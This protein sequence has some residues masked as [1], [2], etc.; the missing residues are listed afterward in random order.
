MASRGDVLSQVF[1]PFSNSPD[2]LLLKMISDGTT[3]AA[4]AS[5]DVDLGDDTVFD[6]A[7]QRGSSISLDPTAP[8]K[9]NLT[10]GL[11]QINF[12]AW[13]QTTSD[14]YGKSDTQI[15]V[16]TDPN[17]V[18]SDVLWN[19]N[20][21][22]FGNGTSTNVTLVSDESHSIIFNASSNITLYFRVYNQNDASKTFFVRSIAPNACTT[23]S[24]VRIGEGV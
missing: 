23:L 9:L 20:L 11:Y 15:K 5:Y 1:T 3:T 13:V 12:S 17:F 18:V 6:V 24:V 14:I 7:T 19:R 16:S 4:G 8:H 22:W 10:K 21:I 2:L